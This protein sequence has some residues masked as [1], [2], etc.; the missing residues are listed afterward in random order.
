MEWAWLNSPD[1]A[2]KHEFPTTA[3]QLR[4]HL[5]GVS[6]PI[7]RRVRVSADITIAALHD[8]I[9]A[10]MGWEDIHL[11]QFFIRGQCYGMPR[12]GA[13]NLHA[14]PADLRLSAFDLKLRERFTYEYD[15]Y[16]QW[17]HDIRLEK[18]WRHAAEQRLPVC[19]A[20]RGACPPEDTGPP[21]RFMQLLDER[22]V[23]VLI[24]R[25]EGE[26]ERSDVSRDQLLD[27]LD[28][29]WPWLQGFDR[30]QVNRRLQQLA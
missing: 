24:E 11:H 25:L 19:T 15:F 18:I 29:W 20:G 27:L 4:I 17:H 30:K 16:S 28:E 1:M 2:E 9:Q 6:P 13:L 3:Y 26:V 7:W 23:Y 8:V 21:E 10:A 12:A 5:R 22:S 14:G